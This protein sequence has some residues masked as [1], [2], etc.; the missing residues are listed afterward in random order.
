MGIGL[1]QFRFPGVTDAILSAV[2]NDVANNN[3]NGETGKNNGNAGNA[4]NGG[5]IVSNI[6]NRSV[7]N[8]Y[9]TEI[10]N[11]QNRNIISIPLPAA[12]PM[13]TAQPLPSLVPDTSN[14]LNS[15]RPDYPLY[16]SNDH[17]CNHANNRMQSEGNGDDK[18]N[19]DDEAESDDSE[20]DS[21]SDDDE[22]EDSSDDDETEESS[23]DEVQFLGQRNNSHSLYRC[24][25]G[26]KMYGKKRFMLHQSQH[27]SSKSRLIRPATYPP[28]LAATQSSALRRSQR[29]DPRSYQSQS[30]T[31]Q[32]NASAQ[33]KKKTLR[34]GLPRD[35]SV[36]FQQPSPNNDTYRT[37]PEYVEKNKH[38]CRYRGCNYRSKYKGSLISHYTVHWNEKPFVCD[39]ES[40]CRNSY[41]S[42]AGLQRHQKQSHAAINSLR[43]ASRRTA[44]V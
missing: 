21:T 25:C 40:G 3:G 15:N 19:E 13:I 20:D 8:A 27:S 18:G 31:Q 16:I 12:P 39:D 5:A 43:Y 7:R 37:D 30:D 36:M 23:D 1:H 9:I 35:I 41:K 14:N 29:T 11:R 26:A 33:Q 17:S 28:A 44:N 38:K 10:N 6:D 34:A 32:S 24:H 42:L 4:N 2:Q 22:T